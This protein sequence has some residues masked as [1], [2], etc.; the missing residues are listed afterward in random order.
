M[1]YNM[2]IFEKIFFLSNLRSKVK[3]SSSPYENPAYDSVYPRFF[4]SFRTTLAS[5]VGFFSQTQNFLLD[6]ILGTR[7]KVFYEDILSNIL[8]AISSEI[9]CSK[10]AI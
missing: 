6:P 4:D 3:I 8:H 2:T 5:S 10:S 7:L 9:S 1:I